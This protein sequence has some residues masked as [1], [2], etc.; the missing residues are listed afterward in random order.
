MVR[1]AIDQPELLP[2]AEGATSRRIVLRR[3]RFG[4][5][6]AL[7]DALAPHRD[8]LMQW[9]EWPR[10]HRRIEDS[11][12]YARRM[13]AEF[14]LRRSMPMAIFEAGSDRYLG[15]AGFHVP[16][17]TTPKV[18]IGYFL[19]PPAR[20]SGVATEV[21]RLQV[22]Y[23]FDQM[24]VNRIWGAC[25]AGNDASAGVMRRAGLREEGVLRAETRDH[26]GR[27]RDTRLFGLTID[28]YPGWQTNHG[29]PDLGYLPVPR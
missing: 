18:E 7:F 9:M 22:H 21:V 29:L 17:W 6:T 20:G 3:Y 13:H 1:P 26:R 16:D 2:L 14:M 12:S 11:E 19:V 8:E 15:G 23:A 25:D 24:Q 4:D 5:G 27:V 10:R 28:D